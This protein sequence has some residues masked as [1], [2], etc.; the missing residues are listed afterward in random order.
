VHAASLGERARRHTLIIAPAPSAG[1][2]RACVAV[3]P[4]R[5]SA[6]GPA[7]LQAVR[8]GGDGLVLVRRD[9]RALGVPGQRGVPLPQ[10]AVG[11]DHLRRVAP[12]RSEPRHWPQDPGQALGH[13]QALLPPLRAAA[14]PTRRR[15]RRSRGA[16]R[17]RGLSAASHHDEDGF[18]D[19]RHR[20]RRGCGGCG[21]RARRAGLAAACRG[22]GAGG[23]A[24]GVRGAAGAAAS[25][26]LQA[27]QRPGEGAAGAAAAAGAGAALRACATHHPRPAAAGP[28]PPGCC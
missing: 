18:A 12:A 3:S 25:S 9:D 8:D 22:Q 16:G 5:P 1:C 19:G 21:G 28:A 17:E 13:R 14:Q 27:G 7:H 2:W 26:P 4:P 11:A 23:Q 15:A 10:L 20:R 6:A 24:A